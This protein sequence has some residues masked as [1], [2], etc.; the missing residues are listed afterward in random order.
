M[1]TLG[2]NS[3]PYVCVQ[4]LLAPFRFATLVMAV[5]PP[6]PRRYG[7]G[8]KGREDRVRPPL[9]EHSMGWGWRNYLVLVH[10]EARL[11]KTRGKLYAPSGVSKTDEKEGSVVVSWVFL[12]SPDRVG[13]LIAT[14]NGAERAALETGLLGQ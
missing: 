11:R 10:E 5:F 9:K 8:S 13:A 1:K 4:M 14:P 12:C 7:T 3:L 2:L 6:G